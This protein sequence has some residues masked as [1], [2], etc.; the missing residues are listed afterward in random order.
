MQNKCKE[1]Q[2]QNAMEHVFINLLW[3]MPMIGR[4]KVLTMIIIINMGNSSEAQLQKCC[5]QFTITN[6]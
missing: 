4:D 6:L 3:N 5:N 1:M 2:K